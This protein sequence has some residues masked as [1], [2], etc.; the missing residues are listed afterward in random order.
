MKSLKLNPENVLHAKAI[1]VIEKNKNFQALVVMLLI[2][3]GEKTKSEAATQSE[4]SALTNR[5]L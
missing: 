5:V 3:H 4:S 1:D 2:E